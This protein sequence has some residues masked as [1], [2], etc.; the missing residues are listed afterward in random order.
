MVAEQIQEGIDKENNF[1]TEQVRVSN[2]KKMEIKQMQEGS[3]KNNNAE[4]GQTPESN[5]KANEAKTEQIQD[6][7]DS[8]ME[9]GTEQIQEE[10]QKEI[11]EKIEKNDFL[12]LVAVISM[13]IDHIGY[14]FFPQQI[15]F[16][17]IGRLAFPIFAFSIVNGYRYTRSFSKYSRRLLIFA[18]IAQVPFML[19]T[20]STELN[21]LFTLLLALHTL[22]MFEKRSFFMAFLFMS[23]ATLVPMDYGIYGIGFV[24]L[25][26]YTRKQK[27]NFYLSPMLF[28]LFYGLYRGSFLQI[29]CLFSLPLMRKR[30][31]RYKIVLPK[32]FFYIFYPLHMLLIDIIRALV[33]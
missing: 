17:V 12:K 8:E 23:I 26:H 18:L 7:T 21:V 6:S 28:T 15:L 25:L 10:N 20:R 4:T 22:A 32:Y 29:F 24:L 19:F 5:G 2:D 1:E 16:R 30:T 13:L 9:E 3:S 14:A 11:E 27:A 31:W 33:S